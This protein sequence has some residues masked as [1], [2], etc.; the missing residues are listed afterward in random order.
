MR[1]LRFNRLI[2]LQKAALVV[3]L[4]L[5][6]SVCAPATITRANGEN[7]GRSSATV[8][9]MDISR[10][11]EKEWQGNVR[12]DAAKSAAHQVINLLEQEN[13][14][15]G[16]HQIGLVSFSR[17]ATLVQPL[18]VDLAAARMAVDNLQPQG[19]T[20]IHAGLTVALQTMAEAASTENKIIIL[21]SDGASNEGPGAAEIL[22]GPAQDAKDTGAC[23]YTVGLGER[24]DLDEALLQDIASVSGCGEYNFAT[25]IH[26]LEKIYIRIRHHASGNI[27]DDFEGQVLQGQ[28]AAAGSFEVPS[29]QEELAISLWWDGANQLDLTLRD[30]NGNL[31]VAGS[32]GVS[33]NNYDNL[34][35]VLL[36]YPKAGRWQ[37]DV[38]GKTIP[39]GTAVYS[40]VVSTRAALHTPTPSELPVTETI[41][42]PAAPISTEPAAPTPEPTPNTALTSM[43]L[44][45]GILVLLI[46]LLC[47]TGAGIIVFLFLRRGKDSPSAQSLQPEKPAS[48]GVPSLYFTQGPL[49]GQVFQLDAE[50]ISIGR[51]S[52]NQIQLPDLAVSRLHAIIRC[53]RGAWFLQ[54]QG[55]KIGCIVNGQR[56]NAIRL[57]HGDRFRIGSS[58][59]VFS[60]DGTEEIAYGD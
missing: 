8:L 43:N 24:G 44:Q 55:S 53:A 12:I 17:E 15:G 21:L 58:E 6:L 48:A 51:G 20:N 26:E 25:D 13:L 18:S 28:S 37:V 9:V 39:A 33:I 40:M 3:V 54:D 14:I 50:S 34:V 49:A 30:P 27:I 35:Y 16:V 1:R 31:Y 47:A 32:P 52:A 41:P 2:D 38:A 19:R 22:A 46:A 42:A 5:W 10:S 60:L 36:A 4:I 11:M 45:N 7:P 29:G 23:V 57:S 59:I 56:V